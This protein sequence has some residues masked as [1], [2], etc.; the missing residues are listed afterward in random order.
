MK[1]LIFA[2]FVLAAL[3]AG[4]PAAVHAADNNPATSRPAAGA[5]ELMQPAD[6]LLAGSGSQ[7]LPVFTAVEIAA[8]ADVLLVQ[9]PDTEAP[10]I[11]YDTKGSTTTKFRAEVRDGVLRI[12][13]RRDLRRVERTAVTVY[14]NTLQKLTVQEASVSFDAP[15]RA[16][17]FDLV[18]GSSAQLK[19]TLDVADL[20][21]ELTGSNTVATLTGKARYM[22]V[23]ASGGR[24]GAAELETMSAEA[25]ATGSS[26]VV[27]Q[28][29]DRLEA[30]TSTGGVV[31]YKGNPAVVRTDEKFM[32]GSIAHEE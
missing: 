29:T 6:S 10:K 4:S 21:L 30:K 12:S 25:N 20:S 26:R 3:A 2:A 9:V 23:Y 15:F 22:R 14:Y 31:T 27:L 5:T 32:G 7:W 18:L 19:A 11:V 24:V 1:R 16:T 8:P 13:E 17:L 28:V